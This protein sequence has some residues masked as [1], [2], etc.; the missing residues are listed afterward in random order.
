[1]DLFKKTTLKTYNMRKVSLFIVSLPILVVCLALDIIKLGP[2]LIV[3][4]WPILIQYLKGNEQDLMM[5]NL[6]YL[7]MIFYFHII[8]DKNIEFYE[9]CKTQIR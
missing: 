6:L 3:C 4:G 9:K 2:W 8:W 5:K 7:G 1:M